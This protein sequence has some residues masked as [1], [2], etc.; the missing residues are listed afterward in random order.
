DDFSDTGDE[1]DFL[2]L[3]RA[4]QAFVEA[5]DIGIEASGDHRAEEES[6][7]RGRATAANASFAAERAAVAV[8]GCDA[9]EG[10]DLAPIERAELRQV[11]DQ[12]GGD[13]V[14]DTGHRGEQLAL[15]A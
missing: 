14:A 2:V 11:A 3:A 12:S 6:G 13:G 1:R 7:A 4:E 8:K 15:V 10:G 5:L 9:S